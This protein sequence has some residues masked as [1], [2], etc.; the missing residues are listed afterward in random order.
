MRFLNG[1]YNSATGSRADK[2]DIIETILLVKAENY[3]NQ[4]RRKY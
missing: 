3:G 2:S 4:T 1:W